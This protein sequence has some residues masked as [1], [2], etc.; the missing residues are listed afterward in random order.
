MSITP[1]PPIPSLIPEFGAVH[2]GAAHLAERFVRRND[3]AR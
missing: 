3:F 1:R 2:A